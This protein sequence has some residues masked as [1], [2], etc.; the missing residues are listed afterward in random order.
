[1]AENMTTIAMAI[2]NQKVREDFEEV[3]HSIPEFHLQ[4]FDP[5]STFDLL[6][7]EIEGE[8]ENEFQ[9]IKSI[10]SSRLVHEIF[11]T[12]SRSEPELL[13]KALKVGVKEF[14]SQ[15]LNKKEV[16][17]T[18]LEFLERSKQNQSSRAKNESRGKIINLIGSKGG[19]GTTT[20]AVNL[21]TS[22]VNSSPRPASV[23][24]LDMNLL[25]GEIPLFL[26]IQP[27]FN[28]AEAARNISRL[29]AHY[30]MSILSKHKSGIRVLPSPTGLD[31]FNVASAEIIARILELMRRAFDF[32][33]IDSGQTLDDVS[34]KILEMSDL[35]LVIATLSLPCLANVKKL[36]WTFVKSG[37]PAN[38]QVKIIINRYHRKSLIS[39]KE[40]EGTLNQKIFGVIDND[41]LTTMSAIN[42]GKSLEMIAPKAEVTKSIKNLASALLESK[43]GLFQ[44]VAGP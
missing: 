24:L 35:L 2:K 17:N 39:L 34:L 40:A 12:S 7:L 26:N 44:R 25:F 41:Y 29:D 33:V 10:Q 4:G 22:L 11:L 13:I 42:Q 19:V 43:A 21:A 31:G 1:M 37:Y 38:G 14:I 20:V 3:I 32:I 18:L 36:L 30:L 16:Q 23:V 15:P 27:E 8:L 9:S 28:W 5:H 6:I